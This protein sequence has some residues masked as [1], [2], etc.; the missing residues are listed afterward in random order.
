MRPTFDRTFLDVAEIISRRATCPR[1]RVGAVITIN[2]RIIATGYNGALSSEEH[3][4]DVGCLIDE[5]SGDHCQ[6]AIHAEMNA[7]AQ[8]ARVGTSI[9]GATL[10]YW[11][12]G[13][14]STM[15]CF[16]C[17]QLMRSVGIVRIVDRDGHEWK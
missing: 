11:D 16:K 9:T 7:V 14:R 3:C 1:A 5:P 4:D 17:W 2:N 13:N 15:N 8:A 10:Y 6:R 12:S